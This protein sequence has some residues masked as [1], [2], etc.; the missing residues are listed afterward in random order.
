VLLVE[1]FGIVSYGDSHWMPFHT[2]PNPA[3]TTYIPLGQDCTISHRLR[4]RGLRA[5]ALPFD[6]NVTPLA[7]AVALLETDFA[8]FLE[9]DALI[10]LPPVPR[11]L[12]TETDGEL[13]ISDEFITPVV[14]RRHRMLFP[15]DFSARGVA[16]FPE[17]REKYLRR[18]QRLREL[19][20]SPAPICFLA[21]DAELNPWQLQ[22]YK[23]AGYPAPKTRASER[24]VLFSRLHKRWP[25]ARCLTLAELEA[26]LD[27]VPWWRRL[28]SKLRS[29]RRNITP[30]SV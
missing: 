30:S 26:Q 14:C 20:R 18:I 25:R 29:P 2:M 11:M 17:V 6:W 19:L 5:A 8:S 16:D 10:Y 9:P 3:A 27:H 12:F 21:H 7:S 4:A 1:K 15:H 22:Q 28:V 23:S 13:K 24:A